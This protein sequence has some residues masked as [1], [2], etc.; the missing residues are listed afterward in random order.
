MRKSSANWFSPSPKETCITDELT[1]AS[2]QGDRV[3]LKLNAS[4]DRDACF[5]PS[6]YYSHDSY[7]NDH[8]LLDRKLSSTM[9]LSIKGYVGNE[10]IKISSPKKKK[11]DVRLKV[12][13]TIK[14]HES[15]KD[16]KEP[17]Y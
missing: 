12:N 5:S 2:K 9:H 3:P 6:S 7:L 4:K 10:E 11:A 8:V 13:S 1:H 17:I 15:N 16:Q 14:R